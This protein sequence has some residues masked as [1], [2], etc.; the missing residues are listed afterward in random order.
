[1]HLP[2]T[3]AALAMSAGSLLAPVAAHANELI[4]CWKAERIAQFLADGRSHVATS[5][6]VI[7]FNANEIVTRGGTADQ[8]SEIR[9]RYS[10]VRPGVYDATMTFHNRRPDLVDSFREYEYQVEGDLLKITTY[11]Q[12]TQPAPPTAAVRVEST[13]RRV[14]CEVKK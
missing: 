3:C 14:D 10:I 1:M 13:S 8:P 5:G 4:G 12:T 9:Y 7:E 2:R 11:P 6:G